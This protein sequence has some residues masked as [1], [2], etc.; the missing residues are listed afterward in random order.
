MEASAK[1]FLITT[2]I[3]IAQTG[4]KNANE[5]NRLLDKRN[6][7]EQIFIKKSNGT[8]KH[9]KSAYLHVKTRNYWSFDI[10]NKFSFKKV[11]WDLYTA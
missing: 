4:N 9:V 3:N 8:C 6:E 1:R 2:R 5:S 11:K 7:F 10:I